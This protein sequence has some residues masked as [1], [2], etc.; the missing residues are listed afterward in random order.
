MSN[1]ISDHLDPKA[2]YEDS[3]TLTLDA[4]TQSSREKKQKQQSVLSSIASEETKADENAAS[5]SLHPD[6]QPTSA[7]DPNELEEEA[8]NEGAFNPVTG[9]INWDCPCLGGMAHGPCGPEFRAA[10]SCFVFSEEEPK[11]MDCIDK[12]KGM[13]DCFRAHPDVYAAE[14]EGD[15]DEELDAGLEEERKELVNEIKERREKLGTDAAE[16]AQGKRLLDDEPPMER[17]PLLRR[18]RAESPTPSPSSRPDPPTLPPSPP[19]SSENRPPPPP[20]PYSSSETHSPMSK[21]HEVDARASGKPVPTKRQLESNPDRPAEGEVFD[22]DLELMPKE[23]HDTRSG[24]TS[25]KKTE[26]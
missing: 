15:D 17:K 25:S 8:S 10:F 13:Q 24:S 21:G 19:S 14:L 22:Q 16:P 9:E 12:F 7:S 2:N 23:W 20:A 5:T 1:A 3:N 11:G 26:K 4:I 6:A 18:S